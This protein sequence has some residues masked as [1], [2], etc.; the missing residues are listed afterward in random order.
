MIRLFVDIYGKKNN[1]NISLLKKLFKTII[2][3]CVAFSWE[4]NEI[5]NK[6]GVEFLTCS[7]LNYSEINWLDLNKIKNFFNVLSSQL[8]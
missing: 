3:N 6:T 5:F 2:R 8:I 1:S 4:L 7:R